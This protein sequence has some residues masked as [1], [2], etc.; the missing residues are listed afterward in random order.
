MDELDPIAVGV[1]D[2]GD[3]DAGAHLAARPD[4]LVPGGANGVQYLV[5]VADRHGPVAVAGAA[6]D[7]VWGCG[8]VGIID[9]HDDLDE[10]VAEPQAVHGLDA[11]VLHVDVALV[12]EAEHVPVKRHH[13]IAVGGD[14]AQVDRVFHDVDAHECFSFAGG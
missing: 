11:D 6:G 13:R 12:L 2:H 4:D 1:L 3:D 10:A 14:D 7:A 9:R 5:E 8:P